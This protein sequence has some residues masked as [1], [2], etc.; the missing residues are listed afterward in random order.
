MAV[1]YQHPDL[2]IPCV[3]PSP[4]ADGS[5]ESLL[6]ASVLL[7][8]SY[9]I[10]Q[11][12]FF[13]LTKY[14]GAVVSFLLQYS[15]VEIASNITHAAQEAG[16]NKAVQTGTV[17]IASTAFCEVQPSQCFTYVKGI[18]VAIVIGAVLMY[19][20]ASRLAEKD[21]KE[22]HAWGSDGDDDGEGSSRSGSAASSR[23]DDG[24][25]VELLH[26]RAPDTPRNRLFSY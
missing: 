16:I 20:H 17:F 18:S 10:H 1:Y 8:V 22:N 9:L 2:L 15:G 12:A 14:S 21:V 11:L 3:V 4:Q 13:Y 7:A 24:Q 25:E 6:A 19:A 5:Y 23:T 26:A